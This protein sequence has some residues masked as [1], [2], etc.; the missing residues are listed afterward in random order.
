MLTH[1]FTLFALIDWELL[2]SPNRK[3]F[4]CGK[5]RQFTSCI[6]SWLTF[7]HFYFLLIYQGRES[8]YDSLQHFAMTSESSVIVTKSLVPIFWLQKNAHRFFYN[9]LFI[10][11]L[12]IVDFWLSFLIISP[13]SY[14]GWYKRYY[15][16][17]L[18]T[19][20]NT[21]IS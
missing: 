19:F 14:T 11:L 9:C 15:I 21:N 3:L 7:L 18:T 20:Y 6:I 10:V 16:R 2:Y 8:F 13:L 5:V 17:K 4:S 1:L 12:Y